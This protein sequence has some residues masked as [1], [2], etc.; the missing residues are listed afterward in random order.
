[1]WN[2]RFYKKD[3]FESGCDVFMASEVECN[4]IIALAK[5][6]YF[7]VYDIDCMWI[8][9]KPVYNFYDEDMNVILHIP[10]ET[11]CIC[12]KRADGSHEPY[13]VY[14]KNL[15]ENNREKQ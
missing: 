5:N 3:M 14:K 4:T 7:Y 2:K 13:S 15:A 1:M 12:F 8:D 10:E 11:L 9:N 6:K